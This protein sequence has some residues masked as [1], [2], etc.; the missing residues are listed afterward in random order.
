[1]SW[2]D[3]L[4]TQ[5]SDYESPKQFWYWSGLSALSAIAKDKVWVE[6]SGR[7]PVYL[8]IYVLLYA[9]SGLRKG[10]PINLAKRLVQKIG[11]TRVIS[12]RS[13]VEAIVE[14]LKEVETNKETKVIITDSCGFI[15]ASEFSSSI[16]HS[17][18]A[19]NTLTD[20]YDRKYNEGEYAIRLIRTGKQI[21]KNPTITMLGGINEA[22]FESFLQDKDITGGFLGRTFIIHA[23]GKNKINSLM[24]EMEQKIDEDRLIEHLKLIDALKGPMIICDSGKKAYNYWYNEFYKVDSEDK[25]G[26]YERIGDSA[27]KIAG[28]LSLSDGVSMEISKAHI[29]GGIEAAE[30][31]TSNV[32][33]V[34]YTIKEEE[35]M[36]TTKKKILKMLVKRQ[37]HK[38]TRADLL[39]SLHGMVNAEDLQKMLDTLEQAKLIKVYMYGDTVIYEMEKDVVQKV[40]LAIGGE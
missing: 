2:L 25:T 28:L 14:G 31:L 38:I 21:L 35:S 26:T 16:V 37:D 23:S 10:E 13:S 30:K 18:F 36:S 4:L 29:I 20:L 40:K 3:E 6:R 19:L 33:H 32:K 39:E 27:L 5:T 12:G 22:H 8:N 1:M 17:E 24:Y 15:T 9:R 11:K 34:T 7:M